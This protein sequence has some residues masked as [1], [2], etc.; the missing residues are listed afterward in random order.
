MSSIMIPS[1]LPSP[2]QDSEKLKKAFQGW[3]TDEKPIIDILGHR[4]ANQRMKICQAYQQLYNESLI[5]RLK[6]E[7]SGDFGTA[8][9][10]WAMDPPKRDAKLAKD[11]LKKKGTVK[12]LSVII[13]IACASIPNHLIAIRQA[14]CSLY[15]CS[16]EEDIALHVDQPLRKL[17]VGM[18]SSYR[19]DREEVDETVA[20]SEADLLHDAIENR[21]LD[22]EQVIWIL[23]TRNRFQLKATF[24]CYHQDYGKPVDQDI[25]DWSDSD[26]AT[27]LRTAVVCIDSPEKHFAEVIKSSVNGLGTDE[28]SLTRAV[29]TR[30]EIDLLKIKEEY[31]KIY[32]TSLLDAVA[33]DTSGDY[34]KFLVALIG[35][36]KLKWFG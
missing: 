36:G 27:L 18:V 24:N 6:S 35:D 28:S 32:D 22:Q 1:P 19:Y 20:K 9:V 10:L 14:Y 13:E 23:G 21:N 31:Q 3:G 17:L 5:D 15:D 4:E 7:L 33:K 29:V 34:K 16:L 8:M 25:K 11:A 12:H 2:T 26:F 30:A